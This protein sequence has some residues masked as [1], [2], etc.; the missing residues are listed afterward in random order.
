[1]IE[2]SARIATK[3]TTTI[4]C[5]GSF[6]SVVRGG[7]VGIIVLLL[8]GFDLPCIE[9]RER[10]YC[11]TAMNSGNGLDSYV[12]VRKDV[13]KE[14]HANNGSLNKNWKPTR[15]RGRDSN[16]WQWIQA[17]LIATA[18]LQD[19]RQD[20]SNSP[21]GQVRLRRVNTSGNS[22][23]NAKSSLTD[24]SQKQKHV[25]IL[26]EDPEKRLRAAAFPLQPS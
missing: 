1:M 19:V 16:S 26:V 20:L 13:L 8:F 23:N 18:E 21:Y 6:G 4:L 25:T 11:G 24:T 12:W 5:L 2:S 9:E 10:E 3:K 14:I 22:P 17:K 7:F 15:K